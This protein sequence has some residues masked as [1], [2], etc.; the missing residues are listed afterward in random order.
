[1]SDR[2][3]IR[4]LLVDDHPIV[5]EG[6]RTVLEQRPDFEVAGEAAD[7]EQA[8]A[9]YGRL[10]PDVAIVDLRLP[11]LD[12]V[13]VIAA[14]RRLDPE[15][16]IVVL[17]SFGGDADVSRALAAGAR[18]FL[19]KGASGRDVVGTLRRVCGGQEAFAA[20]PAVA[21]RLA[22][23]RT[24][25]GL[26]PRETE[27]LE[28]L[29]DGLRDREI[30]ERLGLTVA[31]VKVHVHRI[32]EKLDAQDRTEAVMRAVKRGLIHVDT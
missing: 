12:G 5:R 30:A 10:R 2:P 19:L 22:E 3:K 1:M 4:V 15:A 14:I 13:Q 11:K 16:R 17:T 23:A 6:L 24:W 8:I 27:V 29:A 26:T 21:E 7:G 25:P 9:A 20:T 31:T 32:L 28:F 18:A